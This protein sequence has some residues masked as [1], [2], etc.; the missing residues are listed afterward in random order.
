MGSVWVRFG[1]DSVR[2]CS[3]SGSVRVR[4]GLGRVWVHIAALYNANNHQSERLRNISLTRTIV[5][6]RIVT[7]NNDSET[8]CAKAIA[9]SMSTHQEWP[10]AKQMV[11]REAETNC[12]KKRLHNKSSGNNLNAS[13]SFETTRHASK[14]KSGLSK[15]RLHNKWR[16]DRSQ[17]NRLHYKSKLYI[18]LAWRCGNWGVLCPIPSGFCIV[19]IS[20]HCIIFET[21]TRSAR[22]SASTPRGSLP[23]CTNKI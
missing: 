4:F 3:G 6:E 9:G 23:L 22:S 13:S 11:T 17:E 5:S 15:Y 2:A 18:Y 21:C 8:T 7:K 1:S 12:E 16:T 10:I 14:N 20:L 19:E